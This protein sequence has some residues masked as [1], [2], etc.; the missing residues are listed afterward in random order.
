MT[1]KNKPSFMDDKNKPKVR[2]L[3]TSALTEIRSAS[4][5]VATLVDNLIPKLQGYGITSKTCTSPKTGHGTQ[6]K[7]DVAIGVD[8]ATLEEWNFLYDTASTYFLNHSLKMDSKDVVKVK[9]NYTK[10]SKDLEKAIAD[11]P[12]VAEKSGPKGYNK[13]FNDCL[14]KLDNKTNNLVWRKTEY[15][16]RSIIKPIRKEIGSLIGT[17]LKRAFVTVENAE[18]NNG[19]NEKTIGERIEKSVSTLY[20]AISKA[21]ENSLPTG[22]LL[23]NTDKDYQVVFKYLVAHL[24]T[25]SA[26]NS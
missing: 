16:M 12:K 2:K 25:K 8:T 3:I 19:G 9:K 1:I 11:N 15:S 18:N 6:L 23:N 14:K 13:L 10:F 24:K 4:D 21:D 26:D 20:K 22:F 17:K 5:S 7:S